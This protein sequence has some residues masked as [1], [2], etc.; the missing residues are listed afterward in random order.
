[1]LMLRLTVKSIGMDDDVVDGDVVDDRD[2]LL[3]LDPVADPVMDFIMDVFADPVADP[4]MDLVM[5]VSNSVGSVKAEH[6]DGDN[7][8]CVVTV[9][10][11][12]LPPL[13]IT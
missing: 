9:T 1:M 7:D 6:A 2:D 8:P 13:G 10:G 5:D 3:F 12:D 11:S 4:V